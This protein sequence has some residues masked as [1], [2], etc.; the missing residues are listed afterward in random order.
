MNKFLKTALFFAL[1]SQVA[2]AQK[3][4]EMN[5]I[6][7]VK[8]KHDFNEIGASEGKFV[9][10]SN[11][12]NFT[13]LN[14][15]DGSEKWGVKFKEVAEKLRKIDELIP[16]YD[17]NAV[18]VFERKLGSDQ[19]AVIDFETGKLLWITSKYQGV[20]SDDII[21]VPEL[22][23]F[24]ITTRE[25]LTIVKVRTGEE[26]WSTARLKTPIAKYIYD[27]G[28][29]T[30]TVVNCPGTLLGSLFKG[31]KNQ[32]MKINAKNGEVI[33][34]KTFYGTVEKMVVSRTAIVNLSIQK[35]KVLLRLNGLQVYDY[36]SGNPIW[37]ATYDETLDRSQLKVYVGGGK[38]IRQ[39][40]YY[41]IAE[42]VF[43]GDY[44]Y[45]YQMMNKRN[46]YIKKYEI[47]TGKVV[48]T[49]TEIKDAKV[50]PKMYKIGDKLILQVGGAVYVEAITQ[51]QESAVTGI[52]SSTFSV[53]NKT[54]TKTNNIRKYVNIKPYNVQGFN[55]SDGVSVW[56]SERFKRGI[57]NIITHKNNIVVCSGKALY[58][59]DA[60][61]GNENYE[62]ALG[63]DK[64]NLAEKIIDPTEIEA[65]GDETVNPDNVIIVG[66]KGLSSHNMQTG[67]KV[68]AVRTK[69]GDFNGISG[70]TAFYE[71]EK[72]D[73][74]AIDVNTGKATYYD[75]RK[76]AQTIKGTDGSYMYIF[77]KKQVT[78]VS[79]K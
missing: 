31:F 62:V 25:A 50:L 51:T 42:P 58:S 60:K 32:I 36:K 49:S 56:E 18:F 3:P 53:I 19:M 74:F 1:T 24:A 21:Y 79:T 67:A 48:W 28:E 40:I 2:L 20:T 37:A 12:K 38:V 57:T 34:E 27:S 64:I 23:A 47:N 39:G 8:L 10:G 35:G 55:I 71:T 61:T 66:E 77:E 65:K 6:W 13:L 43:D 41:A 52:N 68:W 17:A 11:E 72:D 54:S 26:I 16:M 76:G 9:Y 15:S 4:T 30:I 5:E 78:K 45:I 59:L 14:A 29:K 46:Q 22:E 73:Q 70:T 44:V 63:D 75:A 69:A 33:W 7:S